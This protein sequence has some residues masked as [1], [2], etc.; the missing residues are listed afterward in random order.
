MSSEE[1]LQL[2]QALERDDGVLYKSHSR[3]DGQ[4]RQAKVA[5]WKHPGN[6]ITGIVA[7]SHKFAG[8]MEKVPVFL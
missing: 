5:M 3:A 1:I 2:K 6:D 7:R 4:G 8:T